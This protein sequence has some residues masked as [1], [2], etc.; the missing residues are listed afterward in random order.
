MRLDRRIK[1]QLI[2][3]SVIA[4]VALAVMICLLPLVQVRQ[5]TDA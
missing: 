2:I 5:R 3:L 4:L 1:I